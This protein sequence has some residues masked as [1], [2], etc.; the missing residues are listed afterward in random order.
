[1]KRE[2][3]KTL[4]ENLGTRYSEILG[5]N[6]SDGKEEEIFKWF[7]AAILFGA[8]ITENS[9]IKT[10]KCFHKYDVLTPNR[11]SETGWDGLVRILDEGSYT[12]YDFKTA[13]KLLEVMQNLIEKYDGRLINIHNKAS[14]SRDLEKRLKNLGKGIGDVTVNI[15]L[16]ELREIWE[17]ADPNPTSLVVLAAENL[18]IVRKGAAAKDA[19]KQLKT[20]WLQNEIAGK[21][22]INF[23]TALLRLGKDYCRKGKCGACLVRSEC[24]IH[25]AL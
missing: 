6:L 4:L 7:L 25:R 13:D 9:A 2:K 20:F 15:F 19:L 17:K 3:L 23:E 5:I 24:P 22:F 18:G 16:R 11:V 21:S 1:M 8:P 14:D 10:F 12:R